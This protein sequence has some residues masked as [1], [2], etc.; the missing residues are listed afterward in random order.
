MRLL[1]VAQKRH[2]SRA[3]EGVSDV[4]SKIDISCRYCHCVPPG[5]GVANS[6]SRRKKVKN[7]KER[8]EREREREA[9]AYY[10]RLS[11]YHAITLHN[12]VTQRRFTIKAQTGCISAPRYK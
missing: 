7:E 2:D 10:R 6:Q 3:D 4:T 8:V 11:Y 5:S 1:S 9:S 12:V